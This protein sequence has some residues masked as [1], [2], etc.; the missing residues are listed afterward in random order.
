MSEISYKERQTVEMNLTLKWNRNR[1]ESLSEL[2]ETVLNAKQPKNAGRK[3]Y[4]VNGT[5]YMFTFIT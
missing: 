2:P 4:P 5:P 3:L 1:W